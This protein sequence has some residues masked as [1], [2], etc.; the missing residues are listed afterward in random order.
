MIPRGDIFHSNI[1]GNK[2]Y[3]YKI[4]LVVIHNYLCYRETPG[5]E[6]GAHRQE[7]VPVCILR[8]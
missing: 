4:G 1:F 5:R 8:S 6:K 3:I 7:R 2:K